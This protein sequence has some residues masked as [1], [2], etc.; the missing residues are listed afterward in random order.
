MSAALVIAELLPDPVGRDTEYEYLTLRSTSDTAQDLTGWQVSVGK[1]L[2]TL[3]AGTQLG[4]GESLQ[5]LRSET[6]L[7]L[8]N[9]GSTVTLLDPTGLAVHSVTYAKAGEGVLFTWN[10]A[11][12]TQHKATTTSTTKSSKSNASIQ[13]GTLS[14]EVRI[15]EVLP[16]P[17]GSTDDGE[18][19]ELHNFG[20]TPVDLA[21]WTLT[22]AAGKEYRITEA[23]LPPEGYLVLPRSETRLA[24]N[25]SGT[26][27]V[28]LHDFTGQEISRVQFRDL[29]TAVAWA[30][31]GTLYRTTPLLTPTTANEFTTRHVVGQLTELG[32][33]S[34]TLATAEGAATVAL[35]LGQPAADMLV[36]TAESGLTVDAYTTLSGDTLESFTYTD[37]QGLATPQSLPLA[38]F[39][40]LGVWS[41][42]ALWLSLAFF[43]VALLAKI[44][45]A[46]QTKIK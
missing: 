27:S 30:Y 34:M 8:T 17:A 5:L 6:G 45:L 11:A 15:S 3:P 9:T 32:D 44:T 31:D 16:N 1:K 39:S 26:E 29:P 35:P 40:T 24:L 46:H 21:G 33:A 19:I 36:L 38:S 41:L 13:T 14:S 25:N 2:Y 12:L 4:A 18:Y 7:A 37:W 20:K 23:L 43:G 42:A 22:D 10:G 28:T